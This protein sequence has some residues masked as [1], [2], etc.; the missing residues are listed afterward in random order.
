MR[1]RLAANHAGGD[2]YVAL[3]YKHAREAVSV[4]ASHPEL[5][6][7][8]RELL[9]ALPGVAAS[10]DEPIAVVIGN[11]YAKKISL[12]LEH[13]ARYAGPEFKKDIGIIARQVAPGPYPLLHPAL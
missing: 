2:H 7:F 10:R 9:F 5:L 11:D 1:D 13:M 4:L 12:F 6:S 8:F 3:Y